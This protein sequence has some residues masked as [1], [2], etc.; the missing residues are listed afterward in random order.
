MGIMFVLPA[1]SACMISLNASVIALFLQVI[2]GHTLVLVQVGVI[3]SQ[4]PWWLLL[5]VS[6]LLGFFLWLI[7]SFFLAP[8]AG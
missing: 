4:C 6:S 7:F 1:N 3:P 2:I 8:L 5:I